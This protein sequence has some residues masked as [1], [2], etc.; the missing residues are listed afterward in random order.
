MFKKLQHHEFPLQ[1]SDWEDMQKRLDEGTPSERKPIISFFTLKNFIAMSILSLL[2]AAI[3][4]LWQPVQHIEKQAVVPKITQDTLPAKSHEK[5]NKTFSPTK[6]RK[7]KSKKTLPFSAEKQTLLP[8]KTLDKLPDFQGKLNAFNQQMQFEKVYLQVDRTLYKPDEDVWFSMYLRDANTLLP[9]QQ[10]QVLY[11]DLLS[12]NGNVQE[13]KTYL[14]LDGQAAGDFHLPASLKGGIYKIRAYTNWMKNTNDAFEREIT[15]Q[16]VVLPNLNMKLEF[17]RKA[18]SSN[19]EVVA[20]FDAN[21]LENKPLRNKNI[22]FKVSFAGNILLSGK[23]KTDENGRALVKFTLPDSLQSNDALL[24][25]TTPYNGQ[26]EAISR[27]VP[28]VL[29]KIDLQFLP[30]GGEFVNT[31]NN[32]IGFKA[33]DEFGKPAD[34]EGVVKNAKGETITRFKSFHDGMG[35][36]DFSPSQNEK[37]SVFITK[38]EGIKTEYALPESSQKGA[39]LRVTQKKDYLD[40]SVATKDSDFETAYLVVQMNGKVL[41]EQ[42]VKNNTDAVKTLEINTSDFPMGVASVTLFDKNNQA[43]NERLVFLNRHKALN[44]NIVANKEKYAPREKVSL[45]VKVTDDKG[46]PV[47]GN[48]SLAVGDDTQLTFADDKEGHILSALLLENDLKGKIEEPNFYFD[49]KEEK[50]LAA[51]DY[52]MLTQG[53]RKMDWKKVMEEKALLVENYQFQ[54]EKTLFTGRILD[55]KTKKPVSG[56]SFISYPNYLHFTTDEY[57]YIAFFSTEINNQIYLFSGDQKIYLDEEKDFTFYSDGYNLFDEKGHIASFIS[58]PANN[59]TSTGQIVGKVQDIDENPISNC[60]IKIY[61]KGKLKRHTF[62]DRNGIYVFNLPSGDYDLIF[63]HQTIGNVK[64][65]KKYL[66]SAQTLSFVTIFPNH[67]GRFNMTTENTNNLNECQ[68]SGKITDVYT[69]VLG[70]TITLY[71]NGEQLNTLYSYTDGNYFIQIKENGLYDIEFSYN[72]LK[73]QRFSKVKLLLGQKQTINAV[74]NEEDATE[75]EEVVVKYNYAALKKSSSISQSMTFIER[76]K[77]S[78]GNLFKSKKSAGN[79]DVAVGNTVKPNSNIKLN[80]DTQSF[81]EDEIL[82]DIGVGNVSLP[83]KPVVI[84]KD[85]TTSGSLITSDQITNLPTRKVSEKIGRAHV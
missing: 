50:S 41:H 60:E 22:D 72:G 28:I 44:I 25:I 20:K 24:N 65:E 27:A 47:K 59:Y 61:Q 9:S 64:H 6:K 33:I 78:V 66:L 11:V 10:S 38:P 62:S 67:L 21:T 16:A 77:V 68:L 52:L 85:N 79:K 73:T 75:L 14:V 53:W 80:Y 71:K 55:K 40:V 58:E 56:Y 29:N 26:T 4:S 69:N 46:K 34:V 1:G 32:N 35:A 63:K 12:P 13:T 45:N 39:I 42:I 18:Y 19:D 2:I 54:N 57:G 83:S 84:K 49:E 3:Y 81:G 7:L 36:F 82:K 74:L 23:A 8:A 43:R 37:Y 48:F 70:A 76:Q 17:E 31:F 30:E 15:L 5:Q 51:L